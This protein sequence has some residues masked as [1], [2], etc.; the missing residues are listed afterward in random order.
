M[1]WQ[2]L[3]EGCAG[4]VLADRLWN[5]GQNI[6]AAWLPAVAATPADGLPVSP[7]FAFGWIQVVANV[8]M[9]GLLIWAV[10]RLY[11]AAKRAHLLGRAA[12]SGSHAVAMIFLL[13]FVLPAWWHGFWAL[14]SAV[15][16]LWVVDV[17]SPWQV[18]VWVAQ[19]GLLALVWSAYRAYRAAA[20]RFRQP[21]T[22]EKFHL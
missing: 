5:I 20:N 4:I 2:R 10:M 7:E 15:Q 14:V 18:L 6:Q 22:L 9:S 8:G 17:R 1:K 16:G 13:A 19:M 12:F 21:E 3:I 11:R